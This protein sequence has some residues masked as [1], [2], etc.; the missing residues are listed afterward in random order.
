MMNNIYNVNNGSVINAYTDSASIENTFN[1]LG[2][3]INYKGDSARFVPSTIIYVDGNRT[4][5][6][7]ANG[8]IIKPFKTIQEAL[9]VE[10]LN[11]EIWLYPK[12]YDETLVF[13]K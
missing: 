4:D 9:D 11:C 7:E 12:I 3:T 10:C 1:D 13:L 8:T 2:G 5:V 6:Y